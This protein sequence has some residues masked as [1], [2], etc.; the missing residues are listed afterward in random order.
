MPSTAKMPAAK[1][2]AAK[3]TVAQA[4]KPPAPRRASRKKGTT[5][6]Q[7]KTEVYVPG[8]LEIDGQLISHNVW[9]NG[10][11]T[12]LRLE[13]V[14]WL[15]LRT[16]ADREGF[17]L[18]ELVTLISRKQHGNASLTATVRAFLLAYFFHIAPGAGSP[19]LGNLMSADGLSLDA[20]AAS[21]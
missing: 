17:K 18:H 10:H 5:P 1:I 4:G 21:A 20:I 2:H 19:I 6:A 12:S 9:V 13:A 15:A 14:M 11:R 16:V 7:L 3:K 8:P